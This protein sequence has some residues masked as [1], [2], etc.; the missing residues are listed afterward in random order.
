MP[1]AEGA[2]GAVGAG[3]G[4]GGEGELVW[5]HPEIAPPAPRRQ[6]P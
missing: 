5:A 6:P 2:A 4:R 3:R 1:A